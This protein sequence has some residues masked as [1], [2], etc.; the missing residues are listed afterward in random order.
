VRQRATQWINRIINTLQKLYELTQGTQIPQRSHK[1]QR[2]FE[3]CFTGRDILPGFP[4]SRPREVPKNLKILFQQM[5]PE[6]SL[7][8]LRK[9]HRER[10]VNKQEK[11]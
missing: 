1:T 6:R 10:L 11:V 7:Q 9:R 8:L 5:A 3:L 2:N 4:S